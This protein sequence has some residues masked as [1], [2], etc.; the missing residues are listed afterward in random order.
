MSFESKYCLGTLCKRGHDYEGTGMSLRYK[1][2]GDCILCH[3][4]YGKKREDVDR[5]IKKIC[6]RKYRKADPKKHNAA[7]M[8]HYRNNLKQMNVIAKMRWEKRK[9]DQKYLEEAARYK[10]RWQQ[11]KFHWREVMQEAKQQPQEVRDEI[12]QQV[13]EAVN[14]KI[15]FLDLHN[16]YKE[17]RK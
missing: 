3:K 4:I 10:Q 1:S 9:Q 15:Q 8:K 13:K 12:L 2:N 5:I 11:K 17:I 6:A 7:V 14:L 16:Q